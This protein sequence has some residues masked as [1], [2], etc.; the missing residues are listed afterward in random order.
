MKKVAILLRLLKKE[1]EKDKETFGI[2]E[3]VLYALKN[4]KINYY[5]IP[6]NTISN[7]DYDNVIEMIKMADGVVI[8][9]GNKGGTKMEFNIIKYLYDNDI[10]TLGICFG[11]QSMGVVFG[12]EKKAVEGHWKLG[13]KYVHY[14]N[15]NKDSLLYKIIGKERMLVNSKHKKVVTNT[16]IPVSAYNDDGMIEAVEDKSKKCFIGVQWHPES[17]MDDDNKKIFDYFISKL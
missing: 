8:P 15:I 13:E 11:H 14:V 9:G 1:D 5:L 12:G 10:P 7:D 3:D 16:N 4:Y 6:I 17:I 2:R